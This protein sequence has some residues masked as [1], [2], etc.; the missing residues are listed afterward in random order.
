MLITWPVI[1]LPASDASSA[2][3]GATSEGWPSRRIGIGLDQLVA[4]G[5]DPG[6]VVRGLDQAERDRIG[7]HAR[8]APFPRQ[9][10]HQRD[11][12]GARGRGERQSGFADP[13]GVSHDRDDAPAARGLQQGTGAM[14]AI[15]RA[16]EAGIDL[17]AANPPACF[18]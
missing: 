9:R 17:L 13:R 14:A 3:I 15:Q 11:G 4:V 12:A 18:R 2:T 10:L 8:T 5:L 1:Q 7:G 16:V 6:L